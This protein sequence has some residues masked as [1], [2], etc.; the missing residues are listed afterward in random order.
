[1]EK[2]AAPAGVAPAAPAGGGPIAGGPTAPAG[3]APSGSGLNLNYPY[4]MKPPPPRQKSYAELANEQLNPGGHKDKFVSG[5]EAAGK[6]DCLG[7]N[8]TGNSNIGPV[9]LSGL[10]AAPGIAVQALQGKCK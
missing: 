1:M 2:P 7:T 5:M 10:F 9:A 3:G 6:P 8:Q 4:L